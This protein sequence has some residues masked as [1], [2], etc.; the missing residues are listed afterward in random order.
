MI[1]LLK[2]LRLY[3]PRAIGLEAANGLPGNCRLF[4]LR[5]QVARI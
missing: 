4:F 3:E 2:E 1:N 5:G